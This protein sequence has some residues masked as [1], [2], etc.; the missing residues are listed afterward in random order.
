V[1][2]ILVASHAGDAN[3]AARGHVESR[4]KSRFSQCTSQQALVVPLH[5]I[6]RTTFL[7]GCYGWN[8]PNWLS[9]RV[10]G[11]Q[12]PEMWQEPRE[13]SG[14]LQAQTRTSRP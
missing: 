11:G 3:S 12:R 2:P 5:T 7:H 9:P 10:A 14:F 4:Q 8:N 13:M 6:H 1:P